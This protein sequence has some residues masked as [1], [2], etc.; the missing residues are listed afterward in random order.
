[1]TAAS[2]G[3]SA[4]LSSVADLVSVARVGSRHFTGQ[5]VAMLRG[6]MFGGQILGQCWSAAA[7]TAAQHRWPVSMQVYFITAPDPTQRIDYEVDVRRDGRRYAW[8]RVVGS[9]RGAV[10]VEAMA[11]LGARSG[12][13][14]NSEQ[15]TAV[16]PE[17][18]PS[19]QEVTALDPD[20]VGDYFEHVT[21]GVLDVRYVEGAPPLR[22]RRGDRELSQRFWVRPEPCGASGIAE[23]G[24]VLAFLSDV[25][26]LAT[27][28][29]ALGELGD[30]QTSY[31][32][33][34]DHAVRFY[35]PMREV[36]WLLVRQES[37]VVSG[38]R[39]ESRGSAVNRAG[40]L[41]F[42]VSQ[43]GLVFRR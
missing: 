14:T 11:A 4:H 17:D 25:N 27:P 30:G 42:T 20:V 22:I 43:G 8:R 34:F 37:V 19:A 40:D 21:M 6:S 3:S 1:M 36:D 31:A 12:P 38:T 7:A 26:L 23:V 29:L 18:L 35:S 2:P 39:V 15:R 28:L 16:D 10:V 32:A 41:V 5:P 13:A 24:A 33:S 9:Q